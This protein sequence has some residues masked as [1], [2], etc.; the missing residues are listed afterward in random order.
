MFTSRHY[1]WCH[2][3]ASGHRTNSLSKYL[4]RWGWRPIIITQLEPDT[5]G[6]I[7]MPLDHI[8]KYLVSLR[9][10]EVGV[11]P[12]AAGPSTGRFLLALSRQMHERAADGGL[13]GRM[14][15]SMGSV[16]T[17]LASLG[18]DSYPMG[19]GWIPK[20]VE[21]GLCVVKTIGVD[22]A[23]CTSGL[24]P[25]YAAYR[26]GRKTGIPWILD[27]TDPWEMFYGTVAR[28]LYL[29][30]LY[31]R[32]VPSAACLS[33][34]T[35]GWA[36]ELS[37][38]VSRSVACLISGF[39][40]DWVDR[41][42]ARRFDE[43]TVLYIGS[44]EV[45]NRDPQAFFAGLALLKR[46]KPE[47]GSKVKVVYVGSNCDFFQ[48]RASEQGV[49]ELL[50]CVGRVKL[51]EVMSYVKGAHLL[52]V[53]L[54]SGLDFN[55]G[56]LTAKVGEYLGTDR[57]ILLT[58]SL[59]KEGD[60]DLARL[61]RETGVGWVAEDAET[62]AKVLKGVLEQYWSTGT[63]MRPAEGRYPVGDF[64]WHGQSHKLALLLDQ[65]ASCK[66]D[67]IVEDICA[68]YPWAAQG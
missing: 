53:A 29:P 54:N 66:R 41:V 37:R 68:A 38:K 52:L 58:Q 14:W 9:Q 1:P 12:V 5:T 7:P 31:R 35:P 65:I 8:E 32:V 36:R 20:A 16:L 40:S 34:C 64:T 10:D 59:S 3:V 43:F 19:G 30:P 6:T 61:V 44:A 17:Y 46:T 24:D 11:I 21:A 67:P 51:G 49:V 2:E 28:Y 55:R 63:T 33:Q 39:D 57:P 45:G 18:G 13:S 42:E 26:L 60:T 22:A 27:L 50:H 4:A 56:R 47:V 23:L 62:V 15:E 48:R 25:V